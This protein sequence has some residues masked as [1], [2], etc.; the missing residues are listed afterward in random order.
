MTKKFIG[1]SSFVLSMAMFAV[2]VL[3]NT[4]PQRVATNDSIA[5]QIACVKT[6]VSARE[7]AIDAAVVTHASAVQSAYTT[8]ATELAGAYSNTTAKTLQ[9]GVK[10]SWADFNKSVKSAATAWKTSRNA[11]WS[12]FRASAK[13]CKAPITVTDSTN[14][15]SEVSGQ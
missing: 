13:A 3:A 9:A 4:L 5:T 6:A 10:V 11:I 7:T 12:T 14:V 1:V 8:R 2:P 15:A